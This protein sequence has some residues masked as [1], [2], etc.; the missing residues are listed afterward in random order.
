VLGNERDFRRALP[1]MH[2]AVKKNRPYLW[3][4][5]RDSAAHEKKD[6]KSK[7]LTAE[8]ITV[9]KN[10]LATIGHTDLFILNE[11]DN[12]VTR[13]DYRDVARELAQ[14]PKMDYAYGVEFLEIDPLNLGL[15]KVKLDDKPAQD[16]IL[17]S[18]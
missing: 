4:P 15:E 10:Q 5:D 18:V 8:Q 16:D 2:T 17:K 12:G 3:N 14:A 11:V 1:R 6:P 13:T 7:P 9:V